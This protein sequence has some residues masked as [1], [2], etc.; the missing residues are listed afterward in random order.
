MASPLGKVAR[1]LSSPQGRRM[2]DQAKT[3]I[4]KQAQDPRNRARIEKARAELKARMAK[5]R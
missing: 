2:V 4:Q 5:K 1:F 3:Q